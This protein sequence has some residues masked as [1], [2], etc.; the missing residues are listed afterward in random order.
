MRDRK[1]GDLWHSEENIQ[2][3]AP[4]CG[5]VIAPRY[6]AQQEIPVP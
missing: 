6:P 4:P 2:Q 3:F 5:Q 1:G